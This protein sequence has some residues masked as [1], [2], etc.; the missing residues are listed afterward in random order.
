V[1]ANVAEYLER[2]ADRVRELGVDDVRPQII[3]GVAAASIIDAVGEAGDQMVVMTTHGRSGIGRWV[4]GSVADHV[5]RHSAGP[6]L[7]VRA[8]I[9]KP[10]S[11]A[12]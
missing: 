12:A 7:L 11:K 1:T 5:A 6:V 4:M 9:A 10:E 3:E 8:D 2:M